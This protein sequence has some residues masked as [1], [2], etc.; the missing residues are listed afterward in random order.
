M[1]DTLRSH[2]MVR[3]LAKTSVWLTFATHVVAAQT[4]VPRQVWQMCLSSDSVPGTVCGPVEF[5]STV[6]A[7]CDGAPAMVY[8]LD[9]SAWLPET[10]WPGHRQRAVT[11]QW[12]GTSLSFGGSSEMSLAPDGVRRCRI[13]GHDGS[14]YGKGVLAGDSIV[15]RW[16]R[17]AFADLGPIGSFVLRA[18]R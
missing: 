11:F 8:S 5:T 15:G 13:D 4:P 14:L 16:G 18:P 3:L 1:A 10:V 7:S 17:R 9:L 2:T 12:A 6:R